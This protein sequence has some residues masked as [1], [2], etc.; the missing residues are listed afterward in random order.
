MLKF[1]N[2]ASKMQ[3]EFEANPV[4]LDEL[5]IPIDDISDDELV[6]HL[7]NVEKPQTFKELCGILYAY[8]TR[9]Y[10]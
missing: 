9:K 1:F 10:V 4:N 6:Q 8:V 7:V 2:F 5:E 3:K